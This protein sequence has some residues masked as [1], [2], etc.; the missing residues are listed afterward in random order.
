MGCKKQLLD[1]AMWEYVI[2]YGPAD[3]GLPKMFLRELDAKLCRKTRVPILI[4][5]DLN[6]RRPSEDESNDSLDISLMALFND[7]ISHHHLRELAHVGGTFTWTN[8]YVALVISVLHR[9]LGL[10]GWE[11]LFPFV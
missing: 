1:G 9:V 10:V 4:A 11:A 6:M 5:R 3:H 8:K 7:F 2:I